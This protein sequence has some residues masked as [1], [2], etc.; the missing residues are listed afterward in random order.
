MNEAGDGCTLLDLTHASSS[1]AHWSSAMDHELLTWH[2]DGQTFVLL[3]T[4]GSAQGGGQ[5]ARFVAHADKTGQV[6]GKPGTLAGSQGKKDTQT[7]NSVRETL[8]TGCLVGGELGG[9]SEAIVDSWVSQVVVQV[10][11]GALHTTN[12]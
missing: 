8:Q 11:D 1:Q 6:C 9:G 4:N 10:L 5:V 7:P 3:W 12:M 2:H